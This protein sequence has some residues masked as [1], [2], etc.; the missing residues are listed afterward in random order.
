[1]INLQGK[2]GCV[3]GL[4]GTGKS[5]FVNTILHNFGKRAFLYDTVG[6]A[7]PNE[8]YAIYQPHDSN[9][10]SELENII[11]IVVNSSKY[12]LIAIDETNRFAP[13]KPAP[14]P[15]KISMLND[16]L[17]HYGLGV[18]Y[19]ARRPCQL[20]QDLTELA[21]YLFIFH[22]KGKSDITYLENI[23]QGLGEAVLNLPLYH[24]IQVNPDR[25]YKQLAPIEPT[26]KWLKHATKM[27]P[28]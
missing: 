8:V 11:T 23:S 6:E 9:S 26:D 17:R 20:N 10:V 24:F 28:K 7:P 2:S 12:R 3:F 16:Q 27:I 4:R 21:D 22:L 25:T 5:T 14:L 13:S 15:K 18:L 1:M 19:I